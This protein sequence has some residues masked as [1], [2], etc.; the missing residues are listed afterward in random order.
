MDAIFW[1]LVYAFLVIPILCWVVYS[2]VR[3]AW[4]LF[5]VALFSVLM[6]ISLAGQAWRGEL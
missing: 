1:L 3:L 2:G 6:L 5:R 4:W